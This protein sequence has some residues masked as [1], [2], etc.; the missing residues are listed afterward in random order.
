MRDY[1]ADHCVKK[2]HTDK[3]IYGSSMTKWIKRKWY[4]PF[5]YLMGEDTPKRVKLLDI[6]IK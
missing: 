1:F 3:A 5:K 4:N 6:I 2:M